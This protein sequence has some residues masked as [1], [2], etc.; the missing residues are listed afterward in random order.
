MSRILKSSAL[1][2]GRPEELVTLCNQCRQ[3]S[4]PENSPELLKI[5]KFVLPPKDEHVT[6]IFFLH[7]KKKKGPRNK[8]PKPLNLCA[9][10]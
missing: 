5:I 10:G 8:F 4:S 7:Y 1:F 2:S 6:P 3:F 9:L